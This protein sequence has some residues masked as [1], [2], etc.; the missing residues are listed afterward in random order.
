MKVLAFISLSFIKLMKHA[1]NLYVQWKADL[2]LLRCSVKKALTNYQL[3]IAIKAILISFLFNTIILGTNYTLAKTEL[4]PYE[5]P[6][7]SQLLDLISLARTN[8]SE[9][10]FKSY[11]PLDMAN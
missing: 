3:H 10:R 11:D 8:F 6:I 9:P 5:S 7:L 2:N 1:N 4:L